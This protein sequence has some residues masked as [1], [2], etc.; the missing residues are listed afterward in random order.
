MSIQHPNL[1]NTAIQVD[2]AGDSIVFNKATTLVI[3]RKENLGIITDTT[4]SPNYK[5]C[6]HLIN[7]GNSQK[8]RMLE[9]IK[10]KNGTRI[11][12]LSI[13]TIEGRLQERQAL[14]ILPQGSNLF[15]LERYKSNCILQIDDEEGNKVFKLAD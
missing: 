13:Y 2:A 10:N 9:I 7:N 15:S 6:V 3:A 8:G 11:T 14:G 1:L 12:Y 5:D 4:H